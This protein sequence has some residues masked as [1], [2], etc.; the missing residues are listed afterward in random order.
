L[1]HKNRE[2]S[3]LSRRLKRKIKAL[4]SDLQTAERQR[5]QS[6]GAASCLRRGWDQLDEGLAKVL[7]ESLP[8][9]ASSDGD[10][11]APS[12]ESNFGLVGH[13]LKVRK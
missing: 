10:T 12:S 2:L 9:E 8:V 11:S 5:L 6:L 3:V 4:R 1:R 13:M 7:G